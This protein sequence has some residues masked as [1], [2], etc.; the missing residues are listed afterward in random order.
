MCVVVVAGDQKYDSH[1]YYKEK[2]LSPFVRPA[3][4]KEGHSIKCEQ[5]HSSLLVPQS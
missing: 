5:S 2:P 4:G 1:P 3:P